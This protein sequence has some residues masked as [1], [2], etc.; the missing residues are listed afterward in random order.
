M[1]LLR[2]VCA[3]NHEEDQ[4]VSDCVIVCIKC[5]VQAWGTKVRDQ[6]GIRQFSLYIQIE[7][8]CNLAFP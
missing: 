6:R 1:N 8:K 7:N 4:R 2:V 3:C 5:M